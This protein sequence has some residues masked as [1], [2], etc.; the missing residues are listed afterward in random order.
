MFILGNETLSGTAVY[1]LLG[2]PT[3]VSGYLSGGRYKSLTLEQ[4][5]RIVQKNLDDLYLGVQLHLGCEG[6]ELTFRNKECYDWWNT[7]VDNVR[8]I[9]EMESNRYNAWEP[10]TEVPTGYY[11]IYVDIPPK[12]I[13]EEL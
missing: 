12:Y 13:F 1:K 2:S 10:Y 11:S 4:A 9:Q 7:V 5:K 8:V 3:L 6:I